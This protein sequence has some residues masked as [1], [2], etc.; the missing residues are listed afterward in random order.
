MA[1][2][3]RYKSAVIIALL[4]FQ[5]TCAFSQG[6]LAKR[7]QLIVGAWS[8]CQGV[9][10]IDTTGKCL[11]NDYYTKHSDYFVFTADGKFYQSQDGVKSAGVWKLTEA[12]LTLDYNDTRNSISPPFTRPIAWVNNSLFY[13]IGQEGKGGVLVF[14]YY[15][16]RAKP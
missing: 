8:H 5:S 1:E 6:L 10:K 9:E 7:R 11:D 2:S 14:T 4:T 3:Q 16:R 12:E 13:E 15:R